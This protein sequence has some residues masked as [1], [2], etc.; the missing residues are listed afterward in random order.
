MEN[1][2]SYKAPGIIYIDVLISKKY[3]TTPCQIIL[4]L[5]CL[6]AEIKDENIFISIKKNSLGNHI[7][8]YKKR[9]HHDTSTI[10]DYLPVL[11]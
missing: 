2:L 9:F 3:S 10:A 11:M 6:I 4:G 7:L 5:K 1:I 8:F